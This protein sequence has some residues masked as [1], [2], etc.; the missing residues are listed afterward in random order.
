MSAKA[1][2]LLRRLAGDCFEAESA[3]VEPGTSKA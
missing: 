3:G 2:A 1:Q